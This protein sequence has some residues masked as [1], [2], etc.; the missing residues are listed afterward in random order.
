MDPSIRVV[1]V[2]KG[3]LTMGGG[4]RDFVWR[5][6]WP[7]HFQISSS[8]DNVHKIRE[9]KKPVWRSTVQMYSFSTCIF[10]PFAEIWPDS[11]LCSLTR[12]IDFSLWLC[13]W[14]EPTGKFQML[15]YFSRVQILQSHTDVIVIRTW[16]HHAG[17]L[18]SQTATQSE[19]P[20]GV[21]QPL[22][23]VASTKKN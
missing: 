14:Q 10:C 11:G 2:S 20:L 17:I 16:S 15:L 7:A 21:T 18:I 3:T 13:P 22:F 8:C 12:W 19:R 6:G 9:L 1:R 4:L 23:W 5:N